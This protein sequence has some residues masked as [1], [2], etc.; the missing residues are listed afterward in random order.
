[1]EPVRVMRNMAGRIG[2]QLCSTPLNKA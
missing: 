1:M 2:I